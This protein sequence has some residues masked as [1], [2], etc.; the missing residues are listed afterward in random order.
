MAEAR[1][2]ILTADLGG[3]HLGL[4]ILAH[5]PDGSFEPVVHKTF[6]S[7]TI[8]SFPATVA[9][10]L[11]QN[12]RRLDPP[13]RQAC[14]DFAGPVGPKRDEGFV[15]NLGWGFTVQELFDATDLEEITLVNDFE[16]VGYGLEVL[17]YSHPDAF[18][19]ISRGGK[20]PARNA[21][22]GTAVVIGAGTGL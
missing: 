14:V 5:R 12:G 18:V 8:R 4:A 10:F 22:K 11:K 6:R 13:V 2:H 9:R 20:L 7:R 3:T 17:L 21:T 19:R 15:T 1:T 16:A